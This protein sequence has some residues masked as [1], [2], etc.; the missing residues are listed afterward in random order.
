VSGGGHAKR[1]AGP[2]LPRPAPPL[3]LRIWQHGRPS[4]ALASALLSSKPHKMHSHTT[5]HSTKLWS[6]HLGPT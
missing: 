2:S 3:Q 5:T 4:N 1:V 6:L